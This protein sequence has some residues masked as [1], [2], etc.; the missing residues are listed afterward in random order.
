MKKIIMISF[1]L[2]LFS[3]Q[4]ESVNITES[5]ELSNEQRKGMI[6]KAIRAKQNASASKEIDI[7][8]TEK[9]EFRIAMSEEKLFTNLDVENGL[10]LQEVIAYEEENNFTSFGYILNESGE[11]VVESATGAFRYSP[12]WGTYTGYLLGNDGCFHH[13]TFFW[14]G[15]MSNYIFVEDPYPPM[16]TTYSSICLTDDEFGAMC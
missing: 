13:G 11:I 16:N 15:T 4:K 6:E 3:C 7:T 1:V 12:G 10:H 5:N 8:D 9:T 14:S 2:F